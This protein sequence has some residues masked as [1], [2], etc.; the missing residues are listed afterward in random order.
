MENMKSLI[1][2]LPVHDAR[3]LFVYL[4]LRVLNPD[5]RW[6]KELSCTR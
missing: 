3:L 2:P 4:T 6:K 5:K 1:K